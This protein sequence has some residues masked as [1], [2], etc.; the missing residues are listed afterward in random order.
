MIR[1]VLFFSRTKSKHNLFLIFIIIVLILFSSFGCKK[2][3]FYCGEYKFIIYR[4]L[5]HTQLNPPVTVFHVYDTLTSYGTIIFNDESDEYIIKYLPD[6]ILN[7]PITSDGNLRKSLST[8]A[9]SP[10]F[11]G[12]FKSFNKIEFSYVWAFSQYDHRMNEDFVIGTKI[13]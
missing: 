5:T 7:I 2:E 12:E 8:G 11:I 13:L 3:D 9:W 6:K 10:A 4:H 1:F